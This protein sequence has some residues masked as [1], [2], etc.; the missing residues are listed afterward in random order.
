MGVIGGHLYDIYYYK[1]DSPQS[2]YQH[3]A[4]Q[5]KTHFLREF[6][7]ISYSFLYTAARN[8]FSVLFFSFCGY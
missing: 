3:V 6:K 1:D 8:L 7:S 2:S 5:V 4:S